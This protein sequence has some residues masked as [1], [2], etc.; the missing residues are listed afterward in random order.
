MNAI[1]EEPERHEIEALLP[2]H[3]A[4]TL[5]RRDANRVEHALAG[6]R[7]LARQS[8]LIR[9]ELVET[10][11]L[12]RRAPTETKNSPRS[13][14]PTPANATNAIMAGANAYNKQVPAGLTPQHDD[15]LERVMGVGAFGLLR[16]ALVPVPVVPEFP[17][18]PEF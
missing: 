13:M 2:W 3:A 6:D 4:G 16:P 12:S 8:E 7:E 9:E 18:A 10:I 15:G 1:D 11:H 17:V 14:P 5:S